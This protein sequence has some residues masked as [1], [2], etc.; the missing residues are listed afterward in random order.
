MFVLD[1]FFFTYALSP[2]MHISEWLNE[3]TFC[4]AGC[5]VSDAVSMMCIEDG[6]LETDELREGQ[7]K[8]FQPQGESNPC[9][10][11]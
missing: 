3:T 8:R 9:G 6:E 4:S 1:T 10:D 11:T 2:E 5:E 7:G